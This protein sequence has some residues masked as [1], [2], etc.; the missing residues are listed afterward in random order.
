MAEIKSYSIFK[1]TSKGKKLPNYY[2]RFIYTDGI[3]KTLC[4]KETSKAAA[5]DYA[6]QTIK[7]EAE[8]TER[9]S[10]EAEKIILEKQKEEIESEKQR[11]ETLR[12]TIEKELSIPTIAD[13]EGFF[14]WG[15]KWCELK[16][17]RGINISKRHCLD[18]EGC[19]K[20]HVLP[21]WGE[22]RV[23]EID[24]A[25]IADFRIHMN[26]DKNL[27][28]NS[29]NKALGALNEILID[30]VLNKYISSVPLIQR[31]SQ[32]SAEKGILNAI[33]KMKLFPD[34]WEFVWCRPIRVSK[35]TGPNR[36]DIE[37]RERDRIM[38]AINVFAY[39]TGCRLGECQAVKVGKVDLKNM[40]VKIDAAH[41]NRC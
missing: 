19:F 24:A 20:N 23:S 18:R 11:L 4:S 30:A 1:R 9:L 16:E 38:Y 29:I 12:L 15:G 31:F 8:K 28:G 3:E 22:Y 33:E 17:S 27:S 37:L 13:Y 25:N 2:C 21:F 32:K 6:Q 36:E 40:T 26:K 35:K 34:D 41:D 5:R 10:I 7:D 39:D 14:K